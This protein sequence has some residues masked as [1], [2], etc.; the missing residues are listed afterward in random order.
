MRVPVVEFISLAA[1]QDELQVV[2]QAADALLEC[3]SAGEV[4]GNGAP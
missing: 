4:M 3:Q 1:C 2:D